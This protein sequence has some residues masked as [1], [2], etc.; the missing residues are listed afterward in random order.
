MNA[1]P[2]IAKVF[3]GWLP[4]VITL[5]TLCVCTTDTNAQIT[6]PRVLSATPDPMATLSE[7]L[8]NRLRA[9][10][11]EQRGYIAHVVE[12]VR[13]QKLDTKLIVAVQHYAIRKKPNYPF[14]YFERAL[15]HEAAK[16]GIA[17]P[18][19]QV[20]RTTRTVIR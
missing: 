5:G 10:T 11:R 12:Q 19:V 9:T 18:R 13:L 8:T 1:R 2:G 14:P 4:I 17:L 16:R 7:Q 3:T 15:R 6:A 20:F